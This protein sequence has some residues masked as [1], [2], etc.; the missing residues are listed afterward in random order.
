M[1]GGTVS[2]YRMVGKTGGVALNGLLFLNL[3]Q[4]R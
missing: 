2:H 4:Q 1:I 3:S